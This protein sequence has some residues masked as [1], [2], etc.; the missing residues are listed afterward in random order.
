MIEKK[1]QG[2]TQECILETINYKHHPFTKRC[3]NF[4]G[5]W[6]LVCSQIRKEINVTKIIEYPILAKGGSGRESKCSLR[7]K[8]RSFTCLNSSINSKT[9]VNLYWISKYID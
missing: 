8:S 2:Y 4:K 9:S 3:I 6:S 7:A 1:V 5:P